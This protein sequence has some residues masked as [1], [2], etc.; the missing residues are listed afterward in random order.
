MVFLCH[1]AHVI[2][3]FLYMHKR[4][5][6][7]N[8]KLSEMRLV[9]VCHDA[10]VIIN[11]LDILKRESWYSEKLSEIRLVQTVVPMS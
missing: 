3:D 7:Y 2:I 5:I 1:D 9:F 6:W 8:E 4:E 11:F 10:H